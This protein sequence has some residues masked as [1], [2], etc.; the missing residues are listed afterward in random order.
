M[1]RTV[2]LLLA[3]LM[4]IACLGTMVACDGNDGPDNENPTSKTFTMTLLDDN[5]DPVAN[6]KVKFID[7]A[8]GKVA[9]ILT[10][11]ANGVASYET[12]DD[13]TLKAQVFQASDYI[14][15]ANETYDFQADGTLELCIDKKTSLKETYTVYVV[16]AS[17][18][19]VEGAY[20]HICRKGDSEICLVGQYTDAEGK[21]SYEVDTGFEWKAKFVEDTEYTDFGDAHEVTLVYTK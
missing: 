18:N 8:T 1:K 9:K 4:L 19:A 5:G 13:V 10:T 2:S 11:D 12:E 20:V 17:G 16:D 21:V 3:A 14:F 6:A 15:D 7:S